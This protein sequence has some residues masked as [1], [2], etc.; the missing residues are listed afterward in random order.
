MS[1]ARA[2]ATELSLGV[3]PST[4]ALVLSLSRRR[5]PASPSRAR[6]A[7]SGGSPWTG[8]WSTLKSPL[9]MITPSGVWRARAQESG[10]EWVVWI[11]STAMPPSWTVSPGVTVVSR[12]LVSRRCS[13]SLLRR[14]PEGERGAEDGDVEAGQDVGE[15]ADVV[16]VAVG[17]H[18]AAHPL[19]PLDQPAH[20]GD[21]QVHPEHLGLGEHQAGVDDHDVLAAFDREEVAA[22]LA[23]PAQGDQAKARDLC[24]CAAP[25]RA[26]RARPAGG[27]AGAGSGAKA[28]SSWSRAGRGLR[29]VG[30]ARRGPGR[31]R[32]A[33]RPAPAARLR[34]VQ[35]AA[36]LEHVLLQGPHQRP[37]VEGGGGV[38]Q[39][40]VEAVAADHPA[41]VEA[42][43][44]AREPGSSRASAWRPRIR[45][46]SGRMIS[47]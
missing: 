12:V 39:G 23:E 35:V 47:I 3:I 6:R 25:A 41:A 42:G 31:G 44:A 7:R 34:L 2:G 17:E 24:G 28:G 27:E 15:G 33:G 13:R 21:D 9:W 20:V 46:T 1:E 14:M 29:R 10:T 36:H 32:R 40:D 26:A 30:A 22:D 45:M 19:A 43:D 8:D 18:D 16:L 11:H 38:V 5:T 4:S 37:L